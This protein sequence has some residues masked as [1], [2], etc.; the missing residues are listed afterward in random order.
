[1]ASTVTSHVDSSNLTAALHE[2]ARLTGKDF[3]Q[4]V[5]AEGVEVLHGAIRNT[6][7]ASVELINKTKDSML[8]E[9]RMA[10][11]G[12]AKKVWLQV[13]E[14]WALPVTAIPQYA[15]NATTPRGD[16]PEDAQGIKNTS[17]ASYSLEGEV[18]RLYWPFMFSALAKAINGRRNFFR[19]NLRKGVFDKAEDIARKYKG[20]M[21]NRSAV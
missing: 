3:E 14:K 4:V 13:S 10:A 21:V 7:A 12:L 16:F 15:Q 1:M 5:N 8:R 9:R 18:Y 11:R 6:D 2:L 19:A 17:G 20:L